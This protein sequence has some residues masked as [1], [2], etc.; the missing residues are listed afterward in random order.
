MHSNGPS[1]LS[2]IGCNRSL[3]ETS[4]ESVEA[5]VD[6]KQSLSPSLCP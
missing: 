5:E 4:E 1:A 6:G 3:S 2:S